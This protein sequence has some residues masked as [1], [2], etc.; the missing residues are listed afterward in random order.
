MHAEAQP[1]SDDLQTDLIRK[2][3]AFTL[4][5]EQHQLLHKS[6]IGFL[7]HHVVRKRRVFTIVLLAIASLCL[8]LGI[9]GLFSS[10]VY[11]PWMMVAA[12]AGLWAY[13]RHQKVASLCATFSAY[14]ADRLDD[15]DVPLTLG[16]EL[17]LNFSLAY[18]E[19]QAVH[20]GDHVLVAERL[21][22]RH[23]KNSTVFGLGAIGVSL[24]SLRRNGLSA[25]P[26]VIVIMLGMAA[27]FAR[28]YTLV[29]RVKLILG[30]HSE[31]TP[32]GR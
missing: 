9:R 26:F 28:D 25:I 13:R 23:W 22:A 12:L 1:S 10:S 31:P 32:D 16:D 19:H 4:S 3:K 29:R 7:V 6:D 8:A 15:D 18:D 27:C 20:A 30:R 24:V 11:L 21:I 14:E 2:L 17:R 5:Y